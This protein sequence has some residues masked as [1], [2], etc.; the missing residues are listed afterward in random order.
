MWAQV[1]CGRSLTSF[2]PM[3]VAQT[4]RAHEDQTRAPPTAGGCA[5][6]PAPRPSLR[7]GLPNYGSARYGD[8]AVLREREQMAYC[9]GRE[10]WRL[11]SQRPPSALLAWPSGPGCCGRFWTA[12]SG[13]LAACC[14]LRAPAGI[15]SRV[16]RITSHPALDA[17]Q[18]CRVCRDE[19]IMGCSMPKVQ[20]WAKHAAECCHPGQPLPHAAHDDY[21]CPP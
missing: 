2:G 3:A 10:P 7:G 19:I 1:V 13:C 5:Q 8:R 17:Y 16:T 6:A 18:H 15:L 14:S 20:T 4:R 21:N 9:C 11:P 12:S